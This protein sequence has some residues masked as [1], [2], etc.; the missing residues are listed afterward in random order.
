MDEDDCKYCD[1]YQVKAKRFS[2]KCKDL[3]QK[4]AKATE[5][6]KFYAEHNHFEFADCS[7]ED[8]YEPETVTNEPENYLCGK[9]SF[10]YEDGTLARTTLAEIEK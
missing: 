5:T 4:L 1:D 7:G 8:D 9:G 3:E 10:T 2:D 6:L